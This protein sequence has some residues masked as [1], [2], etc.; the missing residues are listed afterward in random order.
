VDVTLGKRVRFTMVLPWPM[1]ISH[2]LARKN[3]DVSPS[4][5]GFTW[6]YMV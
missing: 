3:G 4:N 2:D 6:L 1:G 5:L